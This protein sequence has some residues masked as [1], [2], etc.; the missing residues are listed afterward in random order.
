[1]DSLQAREAI[2]ERSSLNIVMF[3]ISFVDQK[4]QGL[5]RTEPARMMRVYFNTGV[6]V[7]DRTCHWRR[8][9]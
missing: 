7:D 1:M 6:E 8:H 4:P 2:S 5:P 9:H 3:N